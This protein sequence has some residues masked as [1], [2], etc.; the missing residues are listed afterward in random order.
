MN[1]K[2]VKIQRSIISLIE[3]TEIKKCI[4]SS[5]IIAY[6]KKNHILY[7]SKYIM[8]YYIIFILLIYNIYYRKIKKKLKP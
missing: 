4:T 3:F 6:I 2:R 1:N 7:S 8:P 5:I